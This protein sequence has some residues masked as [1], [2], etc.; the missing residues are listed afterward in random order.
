VPTDQPARQT[1]DSGDRPRVT[2]TLFLTRPFTNAPRTDGQLLQQ[3]RESA[4]SNVRPT[5]ALPTD[6]PP[7]QTQDFGDRRIQ[8]NRTSGLACGAIPFLT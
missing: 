1:Q 6:Q 8:T 4:I 7:R 2:L 3:A 5:T